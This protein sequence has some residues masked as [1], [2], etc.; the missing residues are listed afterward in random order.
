[1]FCP[2]RFRWDI[3]NSL[4][5]NKTYR[6][7]SKGKWADNLTVEINEGRENSHLWWWILRCG[8][9]L[10]MSC[11]ITGLMNIHEVAW[12]ARERSALY[13]FPAL[14]IAQKYNAVCLRLQI[15]HGTR[16]P[17]D[18]HFGR[19][20]WIDM[21][22]DLI[23][24]GGEFPRVFGSPYYLTGFFFVYE[25]RRHSPIIHESIGPYIYIYII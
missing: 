12:M 3:E 25:N 7:L 24:M 14:W 5:R 1:M 10:M 13:V 22:R 23:L 19:V 15:T 16:H 9:I 18:W 4:F 2:A 11:G 20:P 6:F 17:N 8:A 21:K